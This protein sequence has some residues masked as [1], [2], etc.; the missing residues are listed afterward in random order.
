MQPGGTGELRAGVASGRRRMRAA[1]AREVATPLTATFLGLLLV[2]SLQPAFAGEA[3]AVGGAPS[4]GDPGT[5]GLAGADGSGLGTAGA[6][7]TAGF[8][9]G[10]AIVP[11]SILATGGLIDPAALTRLAGSARFAEPATAPVQTVTA[12]GDELAAPLTPAGADLAGGG[13]AAAIDVA[14]PSLPTGEGSAAGGATGDEDLANLGEYREGSDA[15][16]EVI[17]TP[18][19][20]VYKGGEGDEHV[21]GG[22][23]DDQISG[24]GGDDWLEGGADDDRLDGGAGNDTVDG[25]SGNDQLAGGSGDDKLTGGEGHDRLG[26]DTGD[27]ILV[28]DDPTDT[29]KEMGL[30]VDLGGV[31]TIVVADSY[32][33]GLAKAL[34]GL[35]PDGRATFVMGQADAATFPQGL[36]PYRQQIDPD[37]ENIR[38]EGR[39]AHDVVGSNG[40]NVIEGNLG[41]N[42]L[43][44]RGGDDH[45]LGD[46]GEDWLHGGDGDDWLDGGDG[47]DM[48]YGGGGDDVFV[49]GLHES[50]DQVF[51]HEGSNRLHLSTGE[52]DRVAVELRGSD[53][54][55]TLDGRTLAL[56]RDYAGHEDAYA[57]IDL[58]DGVRS[59]DSLMADPAAGATTLA[60]GDDWLAG[61]LPGDAAA[62]DPLVEPWSAAGIELSAEDVAG[63]GQA[64]GIGPGHGADGSGAEA[65]MP[66]YLP[67]AFAGA[68]FA[69]GDLWLPSDPIG[70]PSLAMPAETAREEERAGAT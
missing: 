50:I 6:G 57:G 9:S 44:G 49:L 68:D 45:I 1:A 55:V 24:G 2:H 70:D 15:D 39:A 35:S 33:Q 5:D 7:S 12:A 16:A 53:L 32:A 66:A 54:A 52:P 62:A 25:G 14:V 58:G 28:L 60:A 10:P 29:A 67:A 36:A 17:L 27:D 8:A 18:K 41:A 64:Q 4:G 65:A 11:G 38:L 61:Y 42:E 63:S 37:I 23:G 48:L 59:F 20:D 22:A 26:G 46:A 69:G 51:D 3:Q 21:V 40:A 30:G 47:G 19:D 34:P 13:A 31:D 43:F 56:V